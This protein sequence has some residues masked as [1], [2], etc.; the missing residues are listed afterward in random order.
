MENKK[1]SISKERGRNPLIVKQ[2]FLGL[3]LIGLILIGFFIIPYSASNLIDS[4]KMVTSK[5]ELK[6]IE[7]FSA[8]KLEKLSGLKLN[9]ARIPMTLIGDKFVLSDA[10]ENPGSKSIP[11]LLFHSSNSWIMITG[12]EFSTS[13]LRQVL[14]YSQES[15]LNERALLNEENLSLSEKRAF[16][17]FMN[18][19]VTGYLVEFPNMIY[20]SA[21]FYKTAETYLKDLDPEATLSQYCF[22]QKIPFWFTSEIFFPIIYVFIIIFFFNQFIKNFKKIRLIKGDFLANN[23][24]S[25]INE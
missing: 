16:K 4:I 18:F 10:Y 14:L 8:S 20:C 5:H 17:Q 2:V 1:Q 7:S 3:I 19:E 25:E 9:E 15:P 21:P 12:E 23:L 6:E 24:F 22:T 13:N 11:I